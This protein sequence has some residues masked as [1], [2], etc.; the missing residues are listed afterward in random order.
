MSNG[1]ITSTES[2]IITENPVAKKY[3]ESADIA[4]RQMTFRHRA[5]NPA[6]PNDPFETLPD[7]NWP[8]ELALIK[9]P[10]PNTGN[11]KVRF[12]QETMLNRLV[13]NGYSFVRYEDC[14]P[15]PNPVKFYFH[16]VVEVNGYAV[17]HNHFL[18]YAN[19]DT[20]ERL[21]RED[22]RRFNE[23]F[24]EIRQAESSKSMEE[25][26]PIVSEQISIYGEEPDITLEQLFEE[27][28]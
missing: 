17:I 24:A 8:F 23:E 12:H 28:R 15:T 10:V 4:T 16:N 3:R 13:A 6:L 2:T 22:I 20:L 19:K 5:K 18:M 14:S 7:S 26:G 11:E 21:R 27:E 1:L 25:G 9:V